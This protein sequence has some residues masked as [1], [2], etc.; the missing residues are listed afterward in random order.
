[1]KSHCENKK[2]NEK[3]DSTFHLRHIRRKYYKALL[4]TQEL[5]HKFLKREESA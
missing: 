1:M 2:A 3:M 5:F 4:N